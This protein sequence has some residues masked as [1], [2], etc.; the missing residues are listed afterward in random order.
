MSR[1]CLARIVL[2]SS[3]VVACV[4]A[5]AET[6][7][8]CGPA[9]D[10]GGP[11]DVGVPDAAPVDSGVSPCRVH[12]DCA[13][14]QSCTR[15]RCVDCLNDEQCGAGQIC[16]GEACVQGCRNNFPPSCEDPVDCPDAY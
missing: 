3:F 7:P 1:L 10:I 15:G 5:P 12:S 2:L 16:V 8:T 14:G 6:C 13:D 11:A 4:D 9:A